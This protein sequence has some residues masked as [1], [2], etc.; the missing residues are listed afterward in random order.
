MIAE[1]LLAAVAQA[2]FDV[3]SLDV[4]D[5]VITRTVETPIDVFALI[6]QRLTDLAG[7]KA[8]SYAVKREKAEK[9][10]RQQAGS[11]GQGE[12][13]L[14]E[15]LDHLVDNWPD[16]APYRAQ[17]ENLE[18]EAELEVIRPV[19]DILKLIDQTRA[20]GKH[21]IFVSDM[22]LA[23]K[24]IASL[25][26]KCGVTH[27]PEDLL[28]SSEIGLTKHA[29]TIWP[30]V[31]QHAGPGK[32][33]LHIGDNEKAD[34]ETPIKHNILALHFTG[35]LSPH[36]PYGP[37]T[38]GI[39]PYSYLARQQQM[40]RNASKEPETAAEFMRRFGK[41]WGVVFMGSFIQW[42]EAKVIQHKIDHIA[43]CAR[44]GWL[45]KQAWEASGAQKRT[46]IPVSY[47]YVSR[48][49]LNIAE[50]AVPTPTGKLNHHVAERLVSG[51]VPIYEMLSRASLTEC[52]QLIAEIKAS[53]PNLN[54]VKSSKKM[55]ETLAKIFQNNSV[56]IVNALAPLRT[57]TESYLRQ[58]LPQQGRIAMV[59]A[60]W[61]ATLQS[62]MARILNYSKSGSSLSGFYVGLFPAAQ[63]RRHSGWMEGAFASDF[64]SLE[65][66][67]GI[68]SA[69]ALIENL[70]IAPHG[71][72][73]GYVQV[74]TSWEPMLNEQQWEADQ[75]RELISHFQRAVIEAIIDQGDLIS[76]FNTASGLSAIS[77]VALSAT[78]AEMQ[79][80]GGLIHSADLNHHG[81]KTLLQAI[82]F[83]YNFHNSDWFAASAVKLLPEVNRH[84]EI[85]AK[86]K[87]FITERLERHVLA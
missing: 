33:I 11:Y 6:E 41:S 72:T 36:R 45:I 4:F 21:V 56:E 38:P 55:T 59:D 83:P 23:G 46:G 70:L 53:Y 3:L 82:S 63:A 73:T 30:Q 31:I 76:R 29:G 5:T 26:A 85:Q 37:L 78:E 10:T 35:A 9:T 50:A 60:G 32:R 2:E 12:I 14:K 44:D 80:L 58:A 65:E 15:I 71:T 77:R 43:F 57:A 28:V 19:P 17:L 86:L 67:T 51:E 66:Q 79:N 40:E 74:G 13:T 54:T 27:A 68:H 75:H 47:L 18:I 81:V 87:K 42:L 24:T 39:L 84:P 49:T 62:A 8:K 1:D 22:Y 25:L 69:V 34:I 52:K 61:H 64:R 20:R 16:L 7:R 48:R